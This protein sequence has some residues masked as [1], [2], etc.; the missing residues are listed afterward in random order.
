MRSSCSAAVVAQ[1]LATSVWPGFLL[2]GKSGSVETGGEAPEVELL[3]AR[4][5]S[6]GADRLMDMLQIAGK[7]DCNSE[8]SPDHS[9]SESSLTTTI[10]PVNGD[11]RGAGM[12]AEVPQPSLSLDC[13]EEP[14]DGLLGPAGRNSLPRLPVQDVGALLDM[15]ETAG[16]S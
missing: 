7:A 12:G 9:S 5:P 16:S 15:P 14:A 4:F 2:A 1:D 11:G 13:E 3:S 6:S 10:A 8:I